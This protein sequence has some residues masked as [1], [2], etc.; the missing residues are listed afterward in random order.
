MDEKNKKTILIVEDEPIFANY[1]VKLL[2]ED[3][4]LFVARDGHSAINMSMNEEPKLILMNVK[5]PDMTG[6][7]VISALRWIEETKKIPVIFITS[8]DSSEER[9]KG[10]ELGAVDYIFKDAAE[11]IIKK[12][13]E[14][15]LGAC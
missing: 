13:V 1:L 2:Q 8:L 14:E 10:F 3:Y 12:S 9:D 7:E 11:D 15:H 6:F 5:M 4:T